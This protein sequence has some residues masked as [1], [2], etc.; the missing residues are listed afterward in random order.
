QNVGNSSLLHNCDLSSL[1][2][3]LNYMSYVGKSFGSTLA[4]STLV[5]GDSAQPGNLTYYLSNLFNVTYMPLSRFQNAIITSNLSSYDSLVWLSQNNDTNPSVNYA[6][7]NYVE[8]GGNLIIVQNP[9]EWLTLV[10]SYGLTAGHANETRLSLTKSINAIT[11]HTIY[12]N[13]L[14]SQVLTNA[15]GYSISIGS[16]LMIE[17]TTHGNG[18]ALLLSGGQGI[19][20][21]LQTSSMTTLIE[22]T[23]SYVQGEASTP[24]WFENNHTSQFSYSI[25][26]SSAKSILIWFSNTAMLPTKVTVNLN[27]EYFRLGKGF[28]VFDPSR[29]TVQSFTS[30]EPVMNF[31]LAP[32]SWKAIYL[33][34][35]NN[36]SLSL[37]LTGK[38]TFES[39]FPNQDMFLI[40]GSKNQSMLL[41]VPFNSSVKEVVLN[42]NVQLPEL[43]ATFSVSNLQEGWL[44]E[45]QTHLLIVSYLST[46]VDS[47]RILRSSNVPV[48]FNPA[49]PLLIVLV[50]LI[51]SEVALAAHLRFGRKHGAKQ[52]PKPTLNGAVLKIMYSLLPPILVL[53]QISILHSSRPANHLWT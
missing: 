42:Y 24:L 12:Y 41:A 14:S 11:N 22:N 26:G 32:L 2:S 48:P 49:E 13:S 43:N 23:I 28:S 18:I 16:G 29:L 34:P 17:Q 27:S 7:A 9:T 52:M 40:T 51:V 3:Q 47:V 45:N 1:T 38:L 20:S 50:V 10:E 33:I 30:S 19:S 31:T 6:I 44:Y 53:D 4:Q 21:V 8:S 15:K 36:D 46:G 35:S 25:T 39:S 37:Y 5:V